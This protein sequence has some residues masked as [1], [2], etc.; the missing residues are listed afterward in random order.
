MPLLSAE[1]LRFSYRAPDA[2]RRAPALDGIDVTLEPGSLTGVMGPTGAGKSTLVRALHR[3]VPGFFRGDLEGTVR[4]RGVSLEGRSVADLAGDI[5]VVLQDFEYQLFSTS[6]ALEV[7]FGPLNLGVPPDEARRRVAECLGAC[8]L[9]GFEDR[10]PS[11]LSGG[12]KQRLAIAAVL[13][14]R[15]G[16]ILLDEPTT[17][18]DPAGKQD[19]YRILA[20]LR[21]DG[22]ALLVVDTE[23]E[24]MARADH[25]LLLAEGRVAGSGPPAELLADLPLLARCGVRPPQMVEVLAGLGLPP[26]PCPPEECAAI[27]RRAGIAPRPDAPGAVGRPGADHS[28]DADDRPETE[29]FVRLDEVRYA[30][31]DGQEVLCGIDLRIQRGE[32]VAILGAN[33]SGKTSLAKII[34]GI[35]PPLRGRALLDGAPI[36][37]QG[38]AGAA[39]RAGYIFQ[40]PDHQIAAATVAE[41]VGF[42]LQ[43]FG[44]PRPE[45]ERRV[46]E[47]LPVVGLQGKEDEDPFVLT[48][49]ERQRLALASVLSYRPDLILMDEPTTGLDETEQRRVMDLLRRLNREG[50]TIIVITHSLPLVARHARRVVVL[51][52]GRVAA[53]GPAR[54]ILG[55]GGAPAGEGRD[56]LAMMGLAPLPVV[57]L[58]TQFGV[59]T[60]TPAE[61][62]ARCGVQP[63]G[64]PAPAF[65]AGR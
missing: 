53:D 60:L 63:G 38:A 50:H 54:R 46:A 42:A 64:G 58:G 51:D 18:L 13:A 59:A 10:E 29:E 14:M 16:V 26:R 2:V 7:A 61:F 3:A 48:K 49:G 65:A 20:R 5:G 23:S 32:F 37:A 28:P 36:A 21:E 31:P 55:A 45:I 24:E 44:A 27:L 41:E 25:L 57:R 35:L 9:A 12:E 4:L 22:R 62:I 6:C 43:N 1:R 47:L 56:P 33:G 39:R 15:P 40:N 34:A 17:D 30:Y 52:R 8:G 19:L 11:S